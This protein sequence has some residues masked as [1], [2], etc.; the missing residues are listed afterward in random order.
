[1]CPPYDTTDMHVI[2]HESFID[3]LRRCYGKLRLHRVK[4]AAD[5]RV[6]FGWGD[7]FRYDL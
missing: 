7:E 2:R 6:T 5:V 1:M 3:N 4:L